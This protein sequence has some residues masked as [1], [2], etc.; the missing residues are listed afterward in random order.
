MNITGFLQLNSNADD[1]DDEAY[2]LA[3]DQAEGALRAGVRLSL[4]EYSSM[5]AELRAAWIEA[6]NRIIRDSRGTLPEAVGTPIRTE[7]EGWVD[8]LSEA[9]FTDK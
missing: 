8:R 2:L 4:A 1:A 6:G 3:C 7:V 9:M 5:T